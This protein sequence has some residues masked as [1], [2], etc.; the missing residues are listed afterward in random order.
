MSPCKSLA[1]ARVAI[2]T[3]APLFRPK[4]AVALCVTTR[5]SCTLSEVKRKM[6]LCGLG[7]EDSLASMPSIVRLCARSRDPNTCVPEP[8]P[9]VVRC[10]RPGCS[11]IRFSGL[12]PFRGSSATARRSTTSLTIALVVSTFA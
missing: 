6:L 11:T 4:S 7:T 2:A 1:P 8:A 5:Y 3:F 10:T 9:L 12:R